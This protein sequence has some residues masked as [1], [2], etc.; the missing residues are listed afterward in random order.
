MKKSIVLP[1]LMLTATP[2]GGKVAAQP[3]LDQ[4]ATGDC[5]RLLFRDP[6]KRGGAETALDGC[7]ADP[8]DIPQA[9][10]RID[11]ALSAVN[12]RAASGTDITSALAAAIATNPGKRISLSAGIFLVTAP[13]NVT[14]AGTTLSGAGQE[15]TIL[16]FIGAAT[17]SGAIRFGPADPATGEYLEGVG[18]EHIALERYA[19]DASSKGLMLEQVLRS[20]I[21]DVRIKDFFIQIDMAGVSNVKI[22]EYFSFF[23]SFVSNAETVTGSRAMIVRAGYNASGVASRQDSYG[24]YVTNSS[25][26]GMGDG[27]PRQETS[28]ELRAADGFYMS[29]PNY[30]GQAVNLFDINPENN[31]TYN[32]NV[33]I[34]GAFFDGAAYQSNNGF[35]ILT[36]SSA[37]TAGV[38]NIALAGV[39][40]ATFRE[41]AIDLQAGD[42]RN[43]TL[44][45]STVVGGR[46]Q[47]L[48]I[49]G[50]RGVAITGNAFLEC[51]TAGNASTGA[52]RY[53][54]SASPIVLGMNSIAATARGAMDVI[55]DGT[56]AHIQQLGNST[57][58]STAIPVVNR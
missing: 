53:G 24:I 3:R 23:G 55:A 19:G 36:N 15:Q 17:P 28:I 26:V 22:S 31:A 38:A 8:L 40:F 41:R 13:I 45:G 33:T 52:W 4:T 34:T 25:F 29:G 44:S 21:H 32:A 16:R 50:V 56:P 48:R 43:V 7:N 49:N 20:R 14:T 6:L 42:Y 12:L 46:L 10:D 35:R 58:R 9:D 27:L 47:C 37:L 1:I 39:N 51:G 11:S 30:V 2:I 57:D 18:L 5:S 54:S